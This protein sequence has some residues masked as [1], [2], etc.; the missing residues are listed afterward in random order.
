V[1][2]RR[3]ELGRGRDGSI[4]AGIWFLK[5]TKKGGRE[6]S[7]RR[8]IRSM[9]PN[10]WAEGK[11]GKGREGVARALQHSRRPIHYG[12]TAR[13]TAGTCGSTGRV[14]HADDA[15]RAWCGFAPSRERLERLLLTVLAGTG[16][17]WMVGGTCTTVGAGHHCCAERVE[18]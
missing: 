10:T 4:Q 11:K 7:E 2:A 8:C 13:T 18:G 17:S 14:L 15:S 12:L 6:S 3:S 1:Q 16:P 9:R 5:R